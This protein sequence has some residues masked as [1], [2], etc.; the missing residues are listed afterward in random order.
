MVFFGHIIY[1][2]NNT[3]DGGSVIDEVIEKCINSRVSLVMASCMHER[4]EI[5]YGLL[6]SLAG[7][8]AKMRLVLL[9]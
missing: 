3:V 9:L 4:Y 5:G 1:I 8:V 6:A 7:V 2:H